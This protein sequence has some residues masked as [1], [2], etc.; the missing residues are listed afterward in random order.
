MGHTVIW[1]LVGVVSIVNCCFAISEK[2]WHSV[3]G[4]AC[5]AM[6]S[7]VINAQYWL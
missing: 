4:W 1:A 7:I 2:N 5:A 3:G 6:G